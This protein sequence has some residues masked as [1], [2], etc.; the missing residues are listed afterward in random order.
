MLQFLYACFGGSPA[1]AREVDKKGKKIK[2]II[3]LIC[4]VPQLINEYS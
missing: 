3:M 1:R 2:K 4:Y